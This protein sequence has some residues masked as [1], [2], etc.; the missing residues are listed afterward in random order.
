MIE[1]MKCEYVTYIYDN[2]L[3]E[4]Q[5]TN[6]NVH[7]HF[8]GLIVCNIL[9]WIS[10]ERNVGILDKS[11]ILLRILKYNV[12]FNIDPNSMVLINSIISHIQQ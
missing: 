2:G 6:S 12:I 4:D 3:T 7:I 1:N 11:K 5:G 10:I 8:C 9:R